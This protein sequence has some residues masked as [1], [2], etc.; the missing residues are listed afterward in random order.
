MDLLWGDRKVLFEPVNLY[1]EDGYFE[2]VFAEKNNKTLG[3]TLAHRRYLKLGKDI[4]EKYPQHLAWNLGKFVL[5]LKSNND[6][7]YLKFLNKYGDGVYSHFYIKDERYLGKKG[8]YIY[9][10]SGKLQYIGRC[11]DSFRK[12]INQGY[13]KIHPKNCYV[14]GQSTNCH[15]NALITKQR[16][17]VEFFVY[18][19]ES[20]MEIEEIEKSLIT[21]YNPPW[22]IA[23]KSTQISEASERSFLP[24]VG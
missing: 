12:R 13:G 23:L 19:S 21:F 18:V 15:L 6:K 9:T 24:G 2:N 17:E 7:L 4:I 1:F 10:V 8:L 5:Y 22:N 3:A 11:R 14:D 20:N 16:K